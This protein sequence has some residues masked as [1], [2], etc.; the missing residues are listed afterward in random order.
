LNPGTA[1]EAKIFKVYH[2]CVLENM[3]VDYAPNGWA[4]FG[5]GHPVQTR[6]TLQF[7]EMD[8]VSK[9]DIDLA[10]FNEDNTQPFSNY[11]ASK[12]TD[13]A[14]PNSTWNFD[15]AYSNLNQK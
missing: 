9:Q 10:K 4:A 11:T 15:N 14:D 12:F 8:I 2:E 6:M 13:S 3:S 1:P 7:R 5:D